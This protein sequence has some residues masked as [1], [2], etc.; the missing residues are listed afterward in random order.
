MRV[1]GVMA[2]E[3]A[4]KGQG[5]NKYLRTVITV[6]EDKIDHKLLELYVEP[7]SAGYEIRLM[8]SHSEE[9]YSEVYKR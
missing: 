2:S 4:Q 6:R 7:T 1:Y 8:D 5:G 3:R 9:L